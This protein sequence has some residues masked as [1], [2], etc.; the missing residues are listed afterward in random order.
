MW[1]AACLV[2]SGYTERSP[3]MPVLN[4]GWAIYRTPP[5]ASPDPLDSPLQP[6]RADSPP[7]H[8][9][10][11][12]AFMQTHGEDFSEDRAL[13]FQNQEILLSVSFKWD[14]VWPAGTNS[15]HETEET[16]R[17]NELSIHTHA[18]VMYRSPRQTAGG[19]QRQTG[20]HDLTTRGR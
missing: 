6:P 12:R 7:P 1:V 18:A 10:M 19:W 20:R 15:Q 5:T 13:V 8:S 4:A 17:V 16:E 11:Y 2:R 9:S 14:L 3:C